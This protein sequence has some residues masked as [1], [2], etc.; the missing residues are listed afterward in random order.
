M[1]L[2]KRWERGECSGTCVVCRWIGNWRRFDSVL[3]P[4][5]RCLVLFQFFFRFYFDSDLSYLMNVIRF[6]YN[7]SLLQCHFDSDFFFVSVSG[8]IL[9]KIEI[10][11]RIKSDS[12][13]TFYSVSF[14]SVRIF[15]GLVLNSERKAIWL[16]FRFRN[17]FR[18][19]LVYRLWFLS[20]SNKVYRIWFEIVKLKR[21]RV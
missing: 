3:S 13:L 12:A 17:Q 14:G 5:W 2:R 1:Q 15:F 6:D 16:C 21:F 9:I 10:F 18:I 4:F 8:F 11:F 19:E 7:T 20:V